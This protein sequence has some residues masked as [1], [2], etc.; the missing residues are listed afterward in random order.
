MT[1]VT[2]CILF[3]SIIPHS[4]FAK[5]PQRN[6]YLAD[7]PN[8][9]GH[10]NDAATDSTEL[11]V[12][13]G[14]FQMTDNGYE[15]VP[16]DALGIPAYTAI[17]DD[18]QVHWYFA[19]YSMRKLIFQNGTFKQ[20]D[21]VDLPV[22]FKN[23]R[24]MAREERLEQAT[25]IQSYLEK[26][27]E[28]GL[29]E[30]LKSSPNRLASAVEDQV[31]IGVLYSLFTKDYALIGSNAHGLIRFDQ[32]DPNDPFSKLRPPLRVT[33]PDHLFDNEK[34]KRNTI[35]PADVVFGL[36]M[37]FNGYL[38]VN[39]LGGTILTLDREN[40]EIIDVYRSSDKG[41]LYTNSFATSHELDGGAIYV[42]SNKAMYR[43][44]VNAQGKISDKEDDGAWRAEYDPGVHLPAGKIADGTGATPTL[45]G[46]SDQEDKLVVITDGAKQM[47][48]VAFWR[49][50]IP[51]DWKQ[52]PGTLSRR[53]ADQVKVNTG[54]ISTIIQSEQS[55][56]T[57]KDYA[58]IVSGVQT[59][60]QKSY[61][62]RGSFNRGLLIGVT[63]NP[64][65]GTSMYQ[66]NHKTHNWKHLW[67]RSD[68]GTLA[69]VPFISGPS[70]MVIVDGYFTKRLGEA[71][72]LG[73]DLDSGE[74]VMSIATGL[75]P[76]FNGTYTGIKCDLDGSLMYTTMFGLVRFDV[77]KM[78]SV[79]KPDSN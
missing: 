12:P 13:R 10:W 7:V 52:R 42:A 23:Y 40:F 64:P 33:L 36:S 27:D 48:L 63:R 65:P 51:V 44:V 66:W 77:T 73:L 6:P 55:V 2:I 25:S 46:F 28:K 16:S 45:M 53:I 59:E 56:A 20:I 9:Q 22:P 43:L 57:Y 29:A 35:F 50:Q 58:F 1:K 37:T 30:F 41:E 5:V 68:I 8:N 17:I 11:A 78:K 15:I 70:N 75:D 19:G 69:T 47:R 26:A 4:I 39:T 54:S 76:I 21:R 67:A 74:T 61:E 62:V 3:L 38:V 18:T 60:R 32:D 72:H 24:S 31:G 79:S 71:F 34:V 14:H 49:D